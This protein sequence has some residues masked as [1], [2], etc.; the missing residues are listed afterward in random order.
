V[1]DA[2]PTIEPLGD[3]AL[4][5]RWPERIDAQINDRVH[6]IVAKIHSLRPAG[7]RDLVPAYAS[8]ALCFDPHAFAPE[9][10]PHAQIERWLRQCLADLSPSQRSQTQRCIEIPVHYGG[11]AGPDLD[12]V[13]DAA[14]C[15][16]ER[17]IALHSGGNYR[18]AMLGF[19]P[20]FPYLSGLDP[21]LEMPRLA[22][23]R[24]RVAAGSV[25]I[26][27]AQTGIYP[28]EGPG[29]WRIIGRTD[30]VLFDPHRDPPSLLAPGDEVRFVALAAPR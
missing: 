12:A 16:R 23:P 26:G 6:A 13:A 2:A 14:G 29:G 8:L 21:R 11:E 18:V 19:A 25:A 5:L 7:L 17:V 22:Q 9:A 24:L 1:S 30:C 4:L 20:G 10:D 3:S 27:G 15:D 28:H